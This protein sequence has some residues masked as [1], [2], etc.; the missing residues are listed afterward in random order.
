M[1]ECWGRG[2]QPLPT[3]PHSLEQACARCDML[4]RIA[5]PGAAQAVPE[6]GGEEV[7]KP[8]PRG[9]Q[10][11]GNARGLRPAHARQGDVVNTGTDMH[12]AGVV[13]T[14]AGV[15]GLTSQGPTTHPRPR[16]RFCCSWLSGYIKRACALT[17]V[18]VEVESP[19]EI[20]SGKVGSPGNRSQNIFP[21]CGVAALQEAHYSCCFCLGAM[22]QGLGAD[23]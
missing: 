3:L 4:R 15:P 23:G 8:R 19:R 14:P 20:P 1:C 21:G 9:R 7:G 22:G 11:R 5:S 2:L 16:I 6:K 17:K 13:R 10:Q 12:R 18:T